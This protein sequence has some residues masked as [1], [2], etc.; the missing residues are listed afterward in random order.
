MTSPYLGKVT[1]LYLGKV[2]SP[3]LGKV[4]SPYLGKVTSPYL[5]TVPS[6]YLGKVTSPYLD[7]VTNP[8][9]GLVICPYLGQ[10]VGCCDNQMVILFTVC[11]TE[12]LLTND[13][14]LLNY[15]IGSSSIP[16]GSPINDLV[17]ISGIRWCTARNLGSNPYFQLNFTSMVSLTYMKA[18]GIH[19][20]YV[21][22]FSLEVQD[23]SGN[24]N[25]YGIT[26]KPTVRK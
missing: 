2:T 8:Y 21:S 23:E 10:E 22:E 26:S 19:E 13:A 24:F 3:Y 18:R 11:G 17:A 6:P 12:Q 16:S 25:S 14:E 4:T 5:G 20:G 9:L 15:I 1:S 7:K